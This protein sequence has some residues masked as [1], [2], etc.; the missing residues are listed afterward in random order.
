MRRSPTCSA[1]RGERPRTAQ[2]VFAPDAAY[3]RPHLARLHLTAHRQARDHGCG[4]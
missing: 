4:R 2:L 1:D 3:N